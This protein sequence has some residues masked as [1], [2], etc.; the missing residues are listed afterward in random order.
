MP[1]TG[2][3]MQKKK[4]KKWLSTFATVPTVYSAPINCE[5]ALIPFCSIHQYRLVTAFAKITSPVGRDWDA[6]IL[7][8]SPST[9][10]PLSKYIILIHYAAILLK[11]RH[12]NIKGPKVPLDPTLHV[13]RHGLPRGCQGKPVLSCRPLAWEADRARVLTSCMASSSLVS[14]KKRCQVW[15]E[16]LVAF[17]TERRSSLM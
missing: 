15:P 12:G 14:W 11:T 16:L 5:L 3:P 10:E 4:K 9:I 7:I 1:H 6:I 13:W 8:P 2:W 17:P